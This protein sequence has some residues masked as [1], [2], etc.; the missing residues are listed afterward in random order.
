M[1]FIVLGD[2]HSYK[3]CIPKVDQYCL[4]RGI[5]HVFQVGDL[6]VHW[7]GDKC[8]IIE[9]FKYHP[10]GPTWISC[11]GNHDN[12][13]QFG[14][15]SAHGSEL[16]QYSKRLFATHRPQYLPLYDGICFLGGAVSTDADYRVALNQ[17][18]WKEEAPNQEQLQ[19][20]AD[21]IDEKKPKHIITH[22][23]PEFAHN[24]RGP[25]INCVSNLP[26]N[27]ISRA[28][29]VIDSISVHRVQNWFFGHHHKLSKVSK[30]S[31]DFYCCGLHG[32]GY[33]VADSVIQIKF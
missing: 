27:A 3:P 33:Q 4:E 15:L 28:F 7:P 12:W 6:G 19:A 14:I 13:T 5:Q 16:V 22:D 24:S 8:K 30:N 9:Y 20:F 2:L 26:Y 31:T 25:G 10:D 18:I 11:L 29:E 1:S 32:E 17:A 23:G 21:L